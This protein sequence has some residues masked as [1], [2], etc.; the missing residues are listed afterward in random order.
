M[1]SAFIAALPDT[2]RSRLGSLWTDSKQGHNDWNHSAC[3]SAPVVNCERIG[4]G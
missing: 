2:W 4:A 1:D 3:Q